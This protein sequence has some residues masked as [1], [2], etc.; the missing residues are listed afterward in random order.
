MRPR[1]ETKADLPEREGVLSAVARVAAESPAL[2][3]RVFG[4]WARGTQS[5]RSDL[6]V[7]IVEETE[8]P[9]L[10]RMDRSA[11][12]LLE[13]LPIIPAGF[14]QAALLP[15][16]AALDKLYIPTRYPD[17]LPGL[18][19][20]DA[21]TAEEAKTAIGQAQRLMESVQAA[22]AAAALRAQT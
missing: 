4:S 6:D 9:F 22:A 19:P 1:P 11:V 8:E 5:R 7:L 10:R 17:A 18:T 15:L 2:E 3:A 13:D 12:K 14:D 16:A 20:A 21:Y